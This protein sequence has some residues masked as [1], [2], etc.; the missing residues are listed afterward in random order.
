M[1][2]NVKA[3]DPDIL[4]F[5]FWELHEEVSLIWSVFAER[6]AIK[7]YTDDFLIFLEKF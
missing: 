4:L 3:I 7:L 5:A 1:A 6:R 2:N